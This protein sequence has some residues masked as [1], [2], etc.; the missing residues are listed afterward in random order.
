MLFLFCL[1][2]PHIS[3]FALCVAFGVKIKSVIEPETAAFFFWMF[4]DA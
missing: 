4:P 1:F 3:V 2:S